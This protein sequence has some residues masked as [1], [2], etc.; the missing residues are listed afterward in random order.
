MRCMPLGHTRQQ[1]SPASADQTSLSAD[2]LGAI[3]WSSSID[4]PTEQSQSLSMGCANDVFSLSMRSDFTIN[5][6]DI[7]TGIRMTYCTIRYAST[8]CIVGLCPGSVCTVRG[9]SYVAP[10]TCSSQ[11]KYICMRYIVLRVHCTA[12]PSNANLLWRFLCICTC[13]MCMCMTYKCNA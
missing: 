12:L 4:P 3:E 5:W 6:P 7:R 1:C 2:L 13:F 11:S 10:P 9:L 8:P